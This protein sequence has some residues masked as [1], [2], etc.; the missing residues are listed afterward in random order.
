MI[1]SQALRQVQIKDSYKTEFGENLLDTVNAIYTISSP[2][3]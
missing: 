1:H 2:Q 3:P